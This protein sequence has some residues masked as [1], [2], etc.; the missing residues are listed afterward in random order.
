MF[1]RF[2]ERARHAVVLAQQVATT[3]IST[4]E[5]LIGLLD[6]REGL[7]AR[8]LEACGVE[9]PALEPVERSGTGQIPFT[10]QAKLSLE[11]GAD[12]ADALGHAYVG[13]EHVLLGVLG[14]LEDGARTLLPEPQKVRRAVLDALAGNG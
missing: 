2:T 3:H 8:V 7:A 6:E 14:H 10:N 12:E 5:L 4:Y 11:A 1:E 9:R 13:T